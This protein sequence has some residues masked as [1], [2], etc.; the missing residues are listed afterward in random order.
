MLI[1]RTAGGV[2]R[3]RC[4]MNQLYDDLEWESLAWASGIRRFRAKNGTRYELIIAKGITGRYQGATLTDEHGEVQTESRRGL[5]NGGRFFL[6]TG[7]ILSVQLTTGLR[8]SVLID[9]DGR[10][11]VPF[12]PAPPMD[13]ARLASIARSSGVRTLLT[14]VPLLAC[15]ALFLYPAATGIASG[16][17]VGAALA[18]VLGLALAI[19]AAALIKLGADRARGKNSSFC[20]L[21]EHAPESIGW[22]YY[23]VTKQAGQTVTG[24]DYAVV[25]HTLDDRVVVLDLPAAAVEPVLRL[26]MIHARKAVVGHSERARASFHELMRAAR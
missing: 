12:E 17:L 21:I 3:T 2:V 25:V 8:E 23:R 15:A 18:G 7:Q 14:A 4:A 6:P 24:G 13:I 16:S 5:M 26:V 10:E 1:S 20:R 11:E 9:L 22:I 19:G